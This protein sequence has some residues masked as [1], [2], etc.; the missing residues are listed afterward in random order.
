MRQHL[1]Y[2]WPMP[3]TQLTDWI[4]AKARAKGTTASAA[5][6][7]AGLNKATVSKWRNGQSPD[8]VAVRAIAAALDAPALEAFVAAGFLTPDDTNRIVEVERPIASIDNDKLASEVARRIKS[9]DL[10]RQFIE[11]LHTGGPL[12]IGPIREGASIAILQ[13]ADEE[14]AMSVA[15]YLPP[16]HPVI[17]SRIERELDRA[18][19]LPIVYTEDQNDV[20]TEPT[21]TGRQGEANPRQKTG[22]AQRRLRKV[23]DLTYPNQDEGVDPPLYPPAGVPIAADEGGA[24]GIETPPGEEDFSQDPEDHQG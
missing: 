24:K 15:L 9:V 16:D 20:T 3:G 19:P 17:D 4:D 12:R 2:A 10:Y 11:I 21:T 7:A 13:E 23:S 8:P 18:L 14:G 1:Q 22:A 5:A 6:A